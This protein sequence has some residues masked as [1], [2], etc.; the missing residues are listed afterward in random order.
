MQPRRREAKEGDLRRE[1]TG[2]AGAGEG[3]ARGSCGSDP[4]AACKIRKPRGSWNFGAG[5]EGSSGEDPLD[6]ANAA[7]KDGLPPYL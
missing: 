1:S 7:G 2:A 4:S 6:I 5:E 3:K